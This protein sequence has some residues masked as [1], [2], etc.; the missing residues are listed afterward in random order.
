METSQ[1]EE[2]LVQ[3]DVGEGMRGTVRVA[4]TGT[5]VQLLS[6]LV[7]AVTLA[8]ILLYGPVQK[9]RKKRLTFE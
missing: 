2:G 1:S 8:G 9:I 4:Y 7:S 6:N 5:T 3:I